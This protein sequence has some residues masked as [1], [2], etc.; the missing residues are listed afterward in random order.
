MQIRVLEV[1]PQVYAC[2]P[3]FESDLQLL[4]KQGVRSII[5]TRPDG[6]ALGQPSSADLAGAAAALD[7]A[8]LH[9]P[10]ESGPI[11][12]ETARA[13]AAASESLARPMMVCSQSG[14][15]ATKIWETSEAT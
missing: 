7:I 13:L 15:R 8:Y 6:A 3:L 2:G 10:V 14:G 1:A 11:S 4:S 9:F 12:P 5:D